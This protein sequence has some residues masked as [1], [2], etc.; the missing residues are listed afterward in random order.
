MKIRRFFILAIL[1]LSLSQNDLL[2]QDSLMTIGTNFWNQDW[3]GADPWKN[4]YQ[5]AIAPDSVDLPEYN[6]WKPE[7]IDEIS[8]YSV[9]RFMDYGEI[10]NNRQEVFWS[11]RTRKNDINQRRM[12]LDWMIDLCN[13]TQSDLWFCIPEKA[14]PDYWQGAAEL[15]KQKLA[16]N[17]RV[18]IEWSNET[19]NPQFTA[20]Q[21]GIDSGKVPD[22]WYPGDQGQSWG[23][24]RLSARYTTFI[25][26][27]IWQKFAEVFGA[28]FDRRVVRALCGSVENNWWDAALFHAL[29]DPKINPANLLPDA[30]GIAPYAGGNLNGAEEDVLN[31]MNQSLAE[32]EKRIKKIRAEIDGT[33]EWISQMPPHPGLKGLPL[34]C[35]EAGQHIVTNSSSFAVNPEAY[36]WYMNYLDMLKKYIKG[37]VAHYT[38]SGTWGNM[39]WGAKDHIGQ[40]AGEAPKFIALNNWHILNVKPDPGPLFSLNVINGLGSGDFYSDM[41]AFICADTSPEGYAFDRWDGDTVFVTDVYKEKTTV[42]INNQ[43]ISLIARYKKAL[44]RVRLE[45]E[46]AQLIGV[47]VSNERAGYSGRGYVKGSSF[48]QENDKITFSIDVAAAGKYR[49]FIGYGGFYGEKYQ[50][51][52]VNGVELAYFYFPPNSAWSTIEYGLIDLNAGKNTIAI[53]KSWGWMDV[54]FIEIE[55]E[56]IVSVEKRS[57]LNLIDHHLFDNYPNPFNA[58]T[59]INYF[60]A[61]AGFVSID[62]YNAMGQRADDLVSAHQLP[63]KYQV[64]WDTADKPIASGAYVCRM[65]VGG[66][67]AEKSMLLLK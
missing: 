20:Y 35:Y 51:L 27:R 22:L 11:D 10:N 17:L 61:R 65:R 37:P 4:G 13:R 34:I 7:F 40:P 41:Y 58:T 48:D 36:A 50:Y 25:S 52:Y 43:N 6:P 19:W 55:G 5:N 31:K 24:A 12:A 67:Q 44:P 29:R 21:T 28:E 38:H 2:A 53:V 54:D 9:L 16:P 45:A 60:I 47:E 56:G 62:V 14:T 32:S 18:Y 59:T 3:G 46:D 66:Y 15:I 33:G 57:G 1:L 63:G 26:V 39:A 64:Q 42:F 23:E 49:L 8:F 30:F